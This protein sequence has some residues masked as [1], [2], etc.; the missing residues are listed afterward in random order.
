MFWFAGGKAADSGT[1]ANIGVER[2]RWGEDAAVSYLKRNGFEIMERNVRPFR[3]D[4]RLE[5]DIVAV[6]RETG[7]VVFVEVKQHAAV[8]PFA[9]R[10]RSVDIRKRRN[11]RT[12]CDAWR[13]LN[14]WKGAFRFD[15]VEVYGVPG[16][17]APVIDHIDRVAMFA[18]RGRF[19]KWK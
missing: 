15:V 16:G 5:I 10:M 4:R 1:T 14:G 7:T 13:R 12:A 2:G 6:E 18:P 8:S 17:G 9:R 3:R 19:V 11:L